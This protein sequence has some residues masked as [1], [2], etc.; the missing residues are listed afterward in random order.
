M[1][2][3]HLDLHPPRKSKI[4]ARLEKKNPNN[5]NN[6]KVSAIISYVLLVCKVVGLSVPLAVRNSSQQLDGRSV[7]F[8]RLSG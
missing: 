3:R 2:I 1:T 7:R 8:F 5:H 6:I 4:D